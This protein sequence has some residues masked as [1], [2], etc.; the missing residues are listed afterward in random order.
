MALDFKC[1]QC[2][3]DLILQHVGELFNIE[4]TR[5]DYVCGAEGC[6]PWMPSR[7]EALSAYH[8]KVAVYKKRI[9]NY[10]ASLSDKTVNNIQGGPAM[11]A[12]DLDGIFVSDFRYITDRDREAITHLKMNMSG[13]IFKPEGAFCIITG[14]P[15]DEEAAT[16]EWLSK[17]KIQP[18]TLYHKLKPGQKGMEYKLQV[19]RNTPEIN[20]FIESSMEQ[21]SFLNKHQTK[22]KVIHFGTFINNAVNHW[23]KN[24]V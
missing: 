16:S 5:P 11:I 1:W 9:E 2:N 3:G 10:Q 23:L 14:R 13:P 12:Y 20:V 19:L 22:C 4:C 18:I 17:N 7:E 21:V 8:E 6:G 24:I 15:A